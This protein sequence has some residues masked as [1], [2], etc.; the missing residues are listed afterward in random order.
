M[1]LLKRFPKDRLLKV[2]SNIHLIGIGGA[3]L[4]AI[5]TVLLQQGYTVSG[6]DIQ[7]SPITERLGQLGATISIGHGSEN[8]AED[9]DAVVVSSA[10][11]DDNPELVTARQQGIPVMKRAEWLGR[12]MEQRVG[13][14]IAGTHGKTTTTAMAAFVLR[15]AG[16][17]PTYIVGGFIK[18]LQTNAAAGTGERHV[19]QVIQAAVDRIIL[20]DTRVIQRCH[21]RR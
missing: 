20:I 14:A 5:A 12:M 10:I 15:E 21:A 19:H 13:I 17:D 1:T 18:Q 8:L 6:S 4:S 3:G 7:P 2:M 16:Q 11:P 9:L